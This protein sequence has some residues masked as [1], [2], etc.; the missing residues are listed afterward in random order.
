MFRQE[1][2]DRAPVDRQPENRAVSLQIGLPDHFLFNTGQLCF[3]HT[4]DAG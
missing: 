1:P 2:G 4:E 3:H